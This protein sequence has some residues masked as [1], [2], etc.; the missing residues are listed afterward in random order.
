[1]KDLSDV[2]ERNKFVKFVVGDLFKQN[3]IDQAVTVLDDFAPTLEGK[4]EYNLIRKDF[5]ST[6]CRDGDCETA[7][8][9]STM[10]T[11]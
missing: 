9:A 8:S 11:S 2:S 10:N 6:F 4:K 7:K 5:A 1:M 3:L